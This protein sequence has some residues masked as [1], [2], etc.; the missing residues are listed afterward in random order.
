MKYP[1][2]LN[3]RAVAQ[4]VAV[5][6]IVDLWISMSAMNADGFRQPRTGKHARGR[7]PVQR[8]RLERLQ[9]LETSIA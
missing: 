3:K 5:I 9:L 7:G 2:H 4:K 8:T 1:L 6:E